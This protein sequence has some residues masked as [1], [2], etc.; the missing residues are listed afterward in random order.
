MTSFFT[1]KLP[2]RVVRCVLVSKDVAPSRG[3]MHGPDPSDVHAVPHLQPELPLKQREVEREGVGRRVELTAHPSEQQV[4]F[5]AQQRVPVMP[6]VE[7]SI[8][9]SRVD[10]VDANQFPVSG[11][12]LE[13]KKK[14][15]VLVSMSVS[16]SKG[17]RYSFLLVEE[18]ARAGVPLQDDVVPFCFG[19]EKAHLQT[20]RSCSEH[21]VTVA[22]GAIAEALVEGSQDDTKQGGKEETQKAWLHNLMRRREY[23]HCKNVLLI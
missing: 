7:L 22:A 1:C 2:A 19:E 11:I 5:V 4:R 9:P 14:K 21:A 6:Q 13:V 12:P 3:R 15:K 23:Q 18:A 20:G 10:F 8:V 16:K 17:S